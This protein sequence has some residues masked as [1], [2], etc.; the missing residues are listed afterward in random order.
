LSAL[1]YPV[2]NISVWKD[3]PE[4]P[5]IGSVRDL[6]LLLLLETALVGLVLVRP[7]FLLYPLSLLSGA[8]VLV[9][10]SSV[11]TVLAVILLGR[12]NSAE[13]WPDALQPIALG[14]LLSLLQIGAIDLVRYAVTGTLGG[15]PIAQ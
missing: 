6:A 12:E 10:L 5:G 8:A 15:L 11:N 1:V 14:V 7:G 9:L 2:F 3:P 4:R 13:A